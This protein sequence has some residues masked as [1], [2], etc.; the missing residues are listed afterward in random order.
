MGK[1]M[2]VGDMIK[3]PVDGDCGVIVKVDD[4]DYLWVYWL[5]LGLM[6]S[7]CLDGELAQSWKMIQRG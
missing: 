3:D 5:G 4:D 6:C 1:R 7:D 2:K